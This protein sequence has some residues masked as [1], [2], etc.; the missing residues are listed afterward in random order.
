MKTALPVAII[1]CIVFN[2]TYSQSSIILQPDAGPGKDVEI[3]S[4]EPNNN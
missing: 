4:L 2:Y 3:F 1:I